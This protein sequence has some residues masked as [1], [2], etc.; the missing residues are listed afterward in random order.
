MAKLKSVAGTASDPVIA[1]AKLTLDDKDY[2]L[3]YSF[4]SIA[5]A[6]RYAGCNLLMGL[7]N[8]RDLSAEQLRGLFYA[9]LQVAHPEITLQK[10]GEMIFL[11]TIAPI[12]AALA[13][14]YTLSMSRPTTAGNAPGAVASPAAN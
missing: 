14:A 4:N 5:L 3:A 9:A 7:E 6:E 8:L 12:T 13:E 1:F 2:R 10:A 11:D